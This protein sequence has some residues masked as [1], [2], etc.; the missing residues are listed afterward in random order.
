MSG[1]RKMPNGSSV[2]DYSDEGGSYDWVPNP[3]AKPKKCPKCRKK[4][5]GEKKLN[6]ACTGICGYRY[7]CKCGHIDGW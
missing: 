6:G 4:M 2:S 5:E 3:F 7:K 1:S